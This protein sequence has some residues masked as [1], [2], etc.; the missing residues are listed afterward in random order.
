MMKLQVYIS[1]DCWTCEESRRIAS[2]VSTRFP[3]VMVELLDLARV[4]RPPDVFATPT[5]VLNGRVISLG[6]P[7]R[8]E[9]W[10]KLETA[11]QEEWV[12]K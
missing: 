5:Y 10:R 11:Q 3:D 8:T 9:L 1:D 2:D 6:N 7:I 4:Q 12:D